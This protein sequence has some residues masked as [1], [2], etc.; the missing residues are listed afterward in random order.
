MNCVGRGF[1]ESDPV[2]VTAPDTRRVSCV[3][4][5]VGLGEGIR[6]PLIGN[7]NPGL[8]KSVETDV[9]RPVSLPATTSARPGIATPSLIRRPVLASAAPSAG[10]L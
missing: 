2:S 9:T 1:A 8:S 6:I 4:E 3:F 5:L 10:L 7:F